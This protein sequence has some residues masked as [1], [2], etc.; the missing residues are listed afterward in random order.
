MLKRCV[1]IIDCSKILKESP[2]DWLLE[3]TN[4]SVRYFTLREILDKSE[5]DPQVMAAKQA[6][7][8]SKVVK[9]IL[10]KQNP[11]GYWEEPANP[12]HPKYKS[13]YWQIMTLGQLGMDKTDER[14]KRACEHIFQFQLKEGGFSSHTTE[15]TLKEYELLV[16]KGKKL[17]PRGE[18]ASSLVFEHQY[19]C[20]TG[21]MVAAL[22]L[23]GY[24]NDS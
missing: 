5:E 20:L 24:K 18:W 2:I 3:K 14:I 11:K 17:P 9:R 13:S 16:K 22:I 15:T 1:I 8:E 6:I 23:L 19:S 7:P 21:N 12:Y 10:S 4:P